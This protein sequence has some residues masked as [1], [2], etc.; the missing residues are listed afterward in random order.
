MKEKRKDPMKEHD[1]QCKREQFY[2]TCRAF[3]PRCPLVTDSMNPSNPKIAE[4]SADSI[5]AFD[6]ESGAYY[7]YLE[8]GDVGMEHLFGYY[9]TMEQFIA[10]LSFLKDNGRLPNK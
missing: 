5:A 4:L 3:Y 8:K 1:R 10:A 6:D 7:Y 9:D 2:I